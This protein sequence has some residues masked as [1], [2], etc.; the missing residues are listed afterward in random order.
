MTWARRPGRNPSNL[1]SLADEVSI[2]RLT[3]DLRADGL[4]QH[5]SFSDPVVRVSCPMVRK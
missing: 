5:P 3:R 2:F 1:A 4:I